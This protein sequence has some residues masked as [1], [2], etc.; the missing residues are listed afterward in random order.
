MDYAGHMHRTLYT[1]TALAAFVLLV[2]N[3]ALSCECVGPND[4]EA[5]RCPVKNMRDL[6]K[7]HSTRPALRLIFEGRVINQEVY[8]PGDSTG[9]GYTEQMDRVTFA[10]V[11]V[12]RGHANR[13]EVV[14][15]D[16]GCGYPFVTGET[17]LVYA[18][19]AGRKGWVTDMC[20]GTT[21]IAQAGAAI[22]FLAGHKPAKE[23][24][25]PR[26]QCRK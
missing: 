3:C 24:L 10:V 8:M 4:S 9:T 7:W 5:G 25:V 16:G 11:H 13:H 6:A 23:D 15:T 26:N 1:Y 21:T 14:T 12:F 17:Y 19:T 2:S 20:S 22:R 18:N